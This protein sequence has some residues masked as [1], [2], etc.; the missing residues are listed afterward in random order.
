MIYLDWNATTPPRPEV[1]AAM[2]AASE[3]SWANPESIHGHGRAAR[4]LVESA[5]QTIARFFSAD[6]EDVLLTSGGTEANNLAV[7][8]AY[9]SMRLSG[10]RTIVLS[11]LEHASVRQ[12]CRR[13][14]LQLPGGTLYE[15]PARPDGAVDLGELG[16]LLEAGDVG[17]VCLQAVNQE[18]GVLQ[19]V[20][21][22]LEAV[23]TANSRLPKTSAA[24]AS[25]GTVTV[26]PG[27]LTLVDTVQAVGRLPDL[28][29][30]A[31]YRVLASHKVRGPKGIGALVTRSGVPRSALFGGGGQ[32]RGL[33]P[34]TVDPMACAGLQKALDLAADG[35]ERYAAVAPLRRTLEQAVLDVAHTCKMQATVL[36]VDALRAPHVSQIVFTGVASAELVAALSLEGLSVS[37][38]SACSAGTVDPSP[39]VE[40]MRG[41]VDAGSALRFSL[42]EETSAAEVTEAIQ[43]VARVLP[44]FA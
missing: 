32:E 17:L 20:S 25:T 37:A 35:P 9:E 14:A 19:P 3:R 16:A 18:T 33:R 41:K 38:G 27:T 34:G 11:A 7:A 23:R 15:L 2:V 13:A 42:G 36:G 31:D 6:A 44:R 28:W 21:A 43:I 40:A 1:V 8:S 5:R 26:D 10:R 12:A 30:E 29:L 4:R 24:R 22:M 39:V